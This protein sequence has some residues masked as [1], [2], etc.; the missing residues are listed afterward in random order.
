VFSNT[1]ITVTGTDLSAVT[2]THVLELESLVEEKNGYDIKFV[3]N[4]RVKYTLKGTDKASGY[5][6]MVFADGEIDGYQ[7]IVSNSVA[8]G[9]LIALDPRDLAV[10]VWS[11]ADIVVDT[12]SRAQFG[13]VRLVIN[14]YVDA[15]LR[16]DR[17]A[18]EIFD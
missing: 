18:C 9:G 15:A 5:G 3:A 17:I 6:Q 7:T 2:Y 8:E 4:P 11:D 10:A 1:A 12:V 13:E 14:Y 16:G